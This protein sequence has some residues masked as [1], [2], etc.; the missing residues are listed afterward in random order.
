MAVIL[1]KNYRELP[2]I[3]LSSDTK[4]GPGDGVYSP[5]SG[6][7]AFESDTLDEYVLAEATWYR[8]YRNSRYDIGSS[9]DKSITFEHAQIHAGRA[10][11][12]GNYFTGVA[13]GANAD[14]L[15]QVQNVTQWPHLQVIVSTRAAATLFIYEA[16]TY[17]NAGTELTVYNRTCGVTALL[18]AEI[19]GTQK[20]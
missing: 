14:I 8:R 4:P 6:A 7:S 13:L 3:C 11:M 20:K 9:C 5:G 12:T 19:L 17:S 1:L 18:E 10:F 16:P 15:V 2:Y